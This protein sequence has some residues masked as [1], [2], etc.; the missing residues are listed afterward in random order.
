MKEQDISLNFQSDLVNMPTEQMWDA[1]RKAK[2]G[3]VI[4]REDASVNQLEEMAAH[5]MGKESA[6]FIPT[7]RMA[8]LVGLMT[9]CGRGNQVVLEE[10]SHIVWSQE[11]GISYICGA[12]PRLIRGRMGA[13]EP[14]DVE[15]AIEESRFKHKPITDVVCLENTHN[16]AG[17]TV[18]SLE[19]T[20]TLCDLAHK[21]GAKVLLDG[22]RIFHAAIALEL[23]PAELVKNCDIMTFNLTKGLSAPAGALLC[24]DKEL[25]EGAYH[26]LGCIGGHSLHKAGILAAAGIIALEKMVD[27]LAEDQMRAKR[28]A[29]KLSQINGIK[30]DMDAIQTNIVMADVS[31]AGVNSDEFLKRIS[32]SGMR[33][34]KLTSKKVR[35][36]FHR[37]ITDTSVKQAIDI[38]KRII[39]NR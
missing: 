36:T 39:N 28:F 33:A 29:Q 38:V 34:H 26:N 24:G 20:N 5:M 10:E 21:Y 13:M 2:I 12:Y 14:G 4:D 30:V 3:W 22:A 23:R 25:V 7:G 32:E 11:W 35:F 1:M 19:Q 17:G 37:H 9:L 31:N 15:A 8:T 16:M 6:L 27:R 18:L